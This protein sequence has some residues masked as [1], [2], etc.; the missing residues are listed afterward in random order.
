[1]GDR[2]YKVILSLGFI[3]SLS[4]VVLTQ[5]RGSFLSLLVIVIL[6]SAIRVFKIKK[7]VNKVI[8]IS[9]VI[10]MILAFLNIPIVKSRVLVAVE[11]QQVYES[12]GRSSTGIRIQL[13]LCGMNI[14]RQGVVFGLDRDN[15]Q[16]LA[17]SGIEDNI[18]PY[19]LE[20]FLIHP[21]PN[22]HNQY[23][24]LLVDSGVIGLAFGLIFNLGPVLISGLKR[25][26]FILSL[27]LSM[28]FGVCLFFD[29]LFLYN[30]VVILYSMIM[31]LILLLRSDSSEKYNV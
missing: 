1:M 13:W 23:V 15:V 19:Y 30:H 25:N 29:S 7:I 4:A 21:N 6:F 24:Q 11:Q 28:Y 20:P 17:A 3:L 8:F 14:L 12:G 5:T 16:K 10:S 22:F 27:S 2:L 18:Y 9:I 31:L 26:H